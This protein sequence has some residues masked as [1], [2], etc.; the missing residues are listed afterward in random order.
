MAVGPMYYG[1]SQNAGTNETFL[2]AD[3]FGGKAL[4][5]S[6]TH[7]ILEPPATNVSV[8]VGG[9]GQVG[10]AG[11][12]YGWGVMGASM[13]DGGLQAG[14]VGMGWGAANTGVIGE[15][16]T[17]NAAWGV[18]G[19]S[20]QGYAGWFSGK[21]H[22]RDS[23]TKGS[24]GFKI[25]H[26]LDPENKYLVHSFVESPDMLNVYSGNVETDGNGEAVV[27]LPGYFEALNQDFTYQ[28]T[29]V[30]QFA[31]AIIA[32]EIRDNRFSIK[33]DKPNVK[34]SWQ[35]TGV[36]QDPYAARNRIT[37]EEEK[38]EGERGLYLHP[39]AYGQSR[40]RDIT[41]ERERAH[42]AMKSNLRHQGAELLDS[43][44]A[45]P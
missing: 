43:H 42:E 17:G 33:T 25:D 13:K 28:L 1:A 30:G 3:R 26:P 4:V 19:R 23:L 10:T 5:A 15:A 12:S 38:L 11:W 20:N 24:G 7:N 9:V 39:E 44:G 22:V 8:G 36:R 6:N 45:K 34:V 37:P 32:E 2:E 16:H 18:W 35:V 21:V 27:I 31:Q 29:G 14:V 41:F 40:S